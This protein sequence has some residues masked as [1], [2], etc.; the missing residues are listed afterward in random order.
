[1]T[2][3]ERL[4]DVMDIAVLIIIFSSEGDLRV[5]MNCLFSYLHVYPHGLPTCIDVSLH[6]LPELCYHLNTSTL[7]QP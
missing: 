4:D 3:Q 2:N 7:P 6:L 1:M 5:D